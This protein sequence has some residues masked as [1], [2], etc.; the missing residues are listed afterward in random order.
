MK[1]LMKERDKEIST[2]T[3]QVFSGENLQIGII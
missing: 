3:Q 2:E 1:Q